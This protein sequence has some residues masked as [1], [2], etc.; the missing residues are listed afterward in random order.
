MANYPTIT[1]AG[2]EIYEQ[3]VLENGI[4]FTEEWIK[5]RE[6]ARCF[7]PESVLRKMAAEI[8]ETIKIR[9]YNNGCSCD[10]TRKT[11]AAEHEIIYKLALSALLGLNH[12]ETARQSKAAEDA[13]INTIEYTLLLMIP[14]ANTYDTLYLKLRRAV[15]S[16]RS[17]TEDE[18]MREYGDA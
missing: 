16:W 14:E 11:T 13:I 10:N 3:I 6:A 17:H 15:G 12:G 18:I 2:R 5:E 9:T 4:K 8:A 1:I 7:L